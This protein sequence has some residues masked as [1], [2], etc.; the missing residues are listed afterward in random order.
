[1]SA[2]GYATLE[3]ADGQPPC[4]T[5]TVFFPK[6]SEENMN[7][8]LWDEEHNLFQVRQS[9]TYEVS[10]FIHCWTNEQPD[11]SLEIAIV[12]DGA[13]PSVCRFISSFRPTTLVPSTAECESHGSSLIKLRYGDS[14]RLEMKRTN[15]ECST[16]LYWHSG[17]TAAFLML[18]RISD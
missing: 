3:A 10:Y 5:E 15:E 2:Y 6:P 16:P 4:S 14:I 12:H 9:G 8:V 11:T 7:N 18:K 1:V 17:G 13:L